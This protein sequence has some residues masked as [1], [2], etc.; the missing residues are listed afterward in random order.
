MTV[1]RIEGDMAVIEVEGR[2]IDFPLHALPSGVK[3]GD[4]LV[5]SILPPDPRDAEAR[6]QRL[7]ARSPQ[8]AGTIDL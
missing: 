5:M 4:T 3:E 6:L 1:D 8:G 7:K 2:L